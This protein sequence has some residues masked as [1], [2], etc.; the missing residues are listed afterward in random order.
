MTKPK[1]PSS[2][3]SGDAESSTRARILDA[4][5]EVMAEVGIDRVRGRAVADRAG[6]NPAL[7]HYY[8]GSMAA[9]VVEAAQHALLDD[10]GPSIEAFASPGTVQEGVAAIL[11]WI[12]E[13]GRTPGAAILAEAMVKGT[14]DPKFRSWSRNAARRF[15]ALILE[16]LEQGRDAGEID[17]A[18][19][20]EATAM[21]LAA[22]LDGLL[23]HHL[24]D[25][26]LAVT[27]AE[28]PIASMLHESASERSS[29]S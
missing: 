3:T 5:V 22:A 16:R 14:R 21:V 10:L 2:G 18:L 7:V 20:L 17:P 26:K 25:P 13:Y 4:T 24:V 29:R 12:V 27:R 15:R 6:V 1:P 19:D 11:D 8:F 23:F 28:G 9:L